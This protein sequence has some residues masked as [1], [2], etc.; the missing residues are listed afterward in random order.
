[1]VELEQKFSWKLPGLFASQS[2]VEMDLFCMKCMVIKKDP[3][4]E[5]DTAQSTETHTQ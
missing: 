5:Q 3:D 4:P 1:M 2:R